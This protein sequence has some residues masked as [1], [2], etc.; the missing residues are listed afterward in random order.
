METNLESEFRLNDYS[1]VGK[2]TAL[3]IEKGLADAKWY[4]SPVPKEKMRELLV[5][6]DGPAIRDT[7]LWFA[8]LLFFGSCGFL[9]WGSAWAILPFA[10]YGILYASV[11]DSRWHESL[12]GTAFKTDWMNNAL[13]ELASFMVLRESIRW[14]WS[15]TRHHSDTLIV[16]LD[17]EISVQRP[18]N[19]TIFITNF[20]NANSIRRYVSSLYLHSTGKMTADERT[21]IPEQEYGKLFTRA[22]IYILIYALVIALSIYTGSILPLMYVGL[23]NI[24]GAWL[25]VVLRLYPARRVG[26]ERAGPPPGLP[27]GL[28]E[29]DQPLPVL[30]HELPCRAP[31][32]PA[33]ALPRPAQAARTHQGRF[34]AAL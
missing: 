9:L 27:H 5:R 28:H 3:A 19:L 7:L 32:V 4:T 22:R 18:P 23:S 16:G 21:Y 24:Y 33:G 11:S 29:P 13:Y 14:R 6:R 34:A 25:M 10:I 15:H 12:H 30:E 2:D 17:P 20:F 31:H 1:L 26:R 8:L